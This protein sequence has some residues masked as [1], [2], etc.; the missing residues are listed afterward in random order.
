V[1]G[2]R[3]QNLIEIARYQTG[4]YLCWDASPYLPSGNII[5][6][7]MSG[8]F[9][10][11]APY[12]VRAC[13]LEGNVT[14][15]NTGLPIN[16]AEV[17]ILNTNKSAASDIIGDYRTGYPTA[18]T[19]DVEFSKPGYITKVETGVVLTNGVLTTLDVQLEP[20]SAVVEVIDNTTGQGIPFAEVRLNNQQGNDVY[21]TTDASGIASINSITSSNYDITGGKWGYRS[22]CVNVSLGATSQV[23]LALDPYIYDDFTF[24][25]FWT[26]TGNA[27]SGLWTRGEPVGTFFGPTPANPGADANTDCSN[28]AKVT[29]NGGGTANTDDVDDGTAILTSPVFDLTSYQ[30]PYLNYER[31]FYQQFASNPAINDTM[32]IALTNGSATVNVEV[33]TGPSTSNSSWVPVSR[34]INDYLTPTSTMQLIVTISDKPGSGNP[35][36]GGLDKFEITEGPTS[37]SDNQSGL[38][39]AYYPNPFSD[40][41]TIDLSGSAT[42]SERQIKI[43]DIT[44]REV[45]SRT[46]SGQTT[47]SVNT[48][49]WNSGIYTVRILSETEM[50]PAFRVVKK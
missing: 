35:L 34:R 37:V 17:K 49:N 1:D 7:D 50:M 20:F 41:L 32:F 8:E 31:W 4:P 21:L 33:V 36:E 39:P 14:D 43:Y 38:T 42:R 45:I 16:V 3:P 5:A 12:Y 25:Y 44:G 13:Y 6:T 9:Y 11:F 10:V 27:I 30:D 19:F 2:A 28:K 24:D 18:G 46:V 26:S 40:L 48:E 15:L 29:G 22:A 47:V 23:T